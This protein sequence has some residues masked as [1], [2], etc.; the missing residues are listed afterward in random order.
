MQIMH[1][2]SELLNKYVSNLKLMRNGFF[3]KKSV[4]RCLLI[5]VFSFVFLFGLSTNVLFI[6]LNASVISGSV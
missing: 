1:K 6:L 3:K 2:L 4:F 5:Q